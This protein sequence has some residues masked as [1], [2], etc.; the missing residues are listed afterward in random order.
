MPF[1]NSMKGLLT[2]SYMKHLTSQAVT[3]SD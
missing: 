1:E 3:K 2:L